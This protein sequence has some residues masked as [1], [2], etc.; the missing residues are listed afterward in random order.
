MQ[1]PSNNYMEQYIQKRKQYGIIIIF[2]ISLLFVSFIFSITQGAAEIPVSRLPE[3]LAGGGTQ[4]EKTIIFEIRIPRAILAVLVGASLSISGVVLQALFRNPMADPYI[5]GIS[6][7]AGFG[8][9]AAMLFGI[10]FTFIGFSG[11]SAAAFFGGIIAILIVYNIA[12]IKGSLPV[13]T[14]LLSGIA[15]GAFFSACIAVLMFIAGNKLHGIVFWLF[16][17]MSFASWDN[18]I[19]IIPY[20]IICSI[21]IYIFSRDLNVMLLGEEDAKA[22]GIDTETV[23]KVLLGC[24]TMLT[25]AAVSVSGLIGFI[26]LVIPHITRI[27]IGPDHR[28]LI[29]A[30]VFIG[31]IALLLTDTLARTII[32]PV[33]IPVG[34]ITSLFG[35]PFFIYLLKKRRHE[36]F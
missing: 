20:F 2:L 28:I 5:L 31:S 7:G 13:Q 1:K 18:I 23:K 34:I 30:S 33:D 16:G 26:G 19:V 10:S 15:V 14:L 9:A 21:I 22:L 4:T 3:I 25:A 32:S 36:Y 17:S 24:A 11:I 12:K 27:L 35:A 8:A 6:S 29:P